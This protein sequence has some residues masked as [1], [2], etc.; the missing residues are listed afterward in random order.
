MRHMEKVRGTNAIKK[1]LYVPYHPVIR[2]GSATTRVRV[3]FNA[4]NVISN[5]TSLNDH[6]H[7]GRKLQREISCVLSSNG[8]DIILFTWRTLKKCSVK[9]VHRKDTDYQR[10]VWRT[11]PDCSINNYCLLTVT[12][13]TI[14]APNLTNRL[15]L[16]LTAGKSESFSDT[17]NVIRHSTYINS[18]LFAANDREKAR[19]RRTTETWW[20]YLT[21]MG[22]KRCSSVIKYSLRRT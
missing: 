9:Y 14:C 22:S 2:E 1:P 12:Y 8:A 6:L 3:V 11:K 21:Q 20:I 19:S 18:V 10:I 15:F 4:S 17:V 5:G 13:G 7:I 16:Q